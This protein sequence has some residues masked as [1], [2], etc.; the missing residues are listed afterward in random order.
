MQLRLTRH[1]LRSALGCLAFFP[2]GMLSLHY[3]GKAGTRLKAGDPYTARLLVAKA[4]F[5]SNIAFALGVL[6]WVAA[7]SW[8]AG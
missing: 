2:C 5:W 8:I 3:S 1:L 6:A 4:D 7:G